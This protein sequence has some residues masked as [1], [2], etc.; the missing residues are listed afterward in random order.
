M[1]KDLERLL[2]RLDATT[3]GL[4]RELKTADRSLTDFSR[5]TD[6]HL[7]KINNSFAQLDRVGRVAARTLAAVGVG[8]SA[9]KVVEYSDSWKKLEGRLRVVTKTE[10]EMLSVRA[11]L[12]KM[13][14]ENRAS[15]SS[16][17]ELYSRLSMAVG[18]NA[19]AMKN[20]LPVTEAISKGIAVTGESAASAQGAIVQFSQGLATNFEA[21]G[22]EIRSL[23]EQA[24]RVAKALA[25]GLNELGIT[26]NATAGSLNKLASDGVINTTNSMQALVTQLPK[27]RKEFEK[28][29]RTVGQAMTNLDN[30][31]LTMLGTSKNVQESTNTLALGIN[32]LANN[33]ETVADAG[34]ILSGVMVARLVP[35]V[36]LSA[37]TAGGA[38]TAHF[39]LASALAGAVGASRTLAVAQTALA[40]SIGLA[41]TAMAM[42][43]GPVGLA[44]I[45]VV[46]ALTL[47]TNR[48]DEA[49]D[50]YNETLG[51]FRDQASAMAD[52]NG[53][54]RAEIEADSERIIKA[55]MAELKSLNSLIDA[56]LAY[57]DGNMAERALGGLAY[58]GSEVMGKL[59]IGNA[60]SELM[61][62]RDH[63]QKAITEMQ[64]LL[65]NPEAAAGGGSGGSGGSGGAGKKLKDLAKKQKE[66]REEVERTT[67]ELRRL[68][69]ARG[70]S[71]QKYEEVADAIAR[72]NELRKVG[73]DINSKEGKS[74]D[75]LLRQKQK[76]E[77][78]IEKIGDAYKQAQKDQEDLVREQER[79]SEQ[80]A[81][82]FQ[83]PFDNAMDNLQSS[84]RDKI[85]GG[86][87]G[88]FD[89]VIDIAKDLAAE[90]ATLFIF[91]PSVITSG[92]GVGSILSGST[93]A[94]AGGVGGSDFLSLGK[95]AYDFVSG[96][97]S[98]LTD[99]VLS[100]GV[101]R[102]VDSFGHSAFGI[103]VNHT[104]PAGVQGPVGVQG[105]F[106]NV[107]SPV[108]IGA[109]MAGSYAASALF[110]EGMGTSIGA[111]VGGL[112][113]GAA[114]AA[115]NLGPIGAAALIFGGSLLGGGLGSLF[116]KKPSSKLQSGQVDL[117][118]GEILGRGGLTGK[119][120]FSQ[121]NFDKVTTLSQTSAAL[122]QIIGAEGELSIAAGNR[123][124]LAFSF[125]H[126][127]HGISAY[128][129]AEEGLRGGF[130]NPNEFFDALI[131]EM[132][133]SVDDINESV[134]IALENIDF[135]EGEK[136]LA[137]ALSDVEF[138][139]AF[140]K[141]GE[142]P[143]IVSAVE[144]AIEA[145]N[146]SFEDMGETADRL[147]L[148]VD[149]ITE[150]QERAMQALTDGFNA[151]LTNSLLQKTNPGALALAAE[152]SR[153]QQ[154]LADAA[155]L[156]GDLQMVEALHAENM[157]EIGA[158]VDNA[159]IRSLTDERQLA[160]AISNDLLRLQNTYD[161]LSQ[162][163]AFGNLSGL[164]PVDQLAATRSRIDELSPLAQLGDLD[165]QAELAE[166]IPAFTELSGEVNGFNAEFAKDLAFTRDISDKT[167]EV[168]DRQLSVQQQIAESAAEEI[169][170]MQQGFADMV[171]ALS[172]GGVGSSGATN[173]AG[174]RLNKIAISGLG[175][176]DLTVGQ[177]E[178]I[179]RS[180]TGHTGTSGNG[181]LAA[182]ISAQGLQAQFDSL[183]KKAA[184]VPGFA[185]GGLIGG[186]L[187]GK[188]SVLIKAMPDEFMLRAAAV[189]SIG[190]DKVARMNATG[191]MPNNDN[192]AREIRALRSD[193]SKMTQVIAASGEMNADGQ[194]A[195]LGSLNKI[196]S[197]GGVAKWR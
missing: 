60:P 186:G 54:R 58:V 29:P 22:Q 161:S 40:G 93:T 88:G 24:P 48:A 141:L 89:D 136:A 63:L 74:L 37:T 124:G 33:L 121:A 39:A 177:V 80:L 189:K 18:N 7:G 76:H 173:A 77:A 154:Q 125:G 6:R 112:G 183:I 151:S 188:D 2:I 137:Q 56:Y 67:D 140:D 32:G 196:A 34:V 11:K 192:T 120:K 195:M 71:E 19:E 178:A 17:V 171:A 169:L 53:D 172:G 132:M 123:D 114:A 179:G 110:G 109:G 96:G 30:A 42:L 167:K 68:A 43:G 155:R 184:G 152:I 46:T 85:R 79:I 47:H 3:E 59:G 182:L 190:V 159:R 117:E 95:N 98:G 149:K 9:R 45:G 99:S 28:M 27:L 90:L 143:E 15:I 44:I 13:A 194:A 31:F 119:K 162:R 65:N 16:Q 92:L 49:Q 8:V 105:G 87:K 133:E 14:E 116:N 102:A 12:L 147:G 5:K 163:L 193:I 97:F 138:A 128:P 166:L 156:G 145:L 4:R 130:Q 52:A 108:N 64:Q 180:L 126:D 55:H 21:A 131:D 61:D 75:E 139:A 170:V 86:F 181:E 144:Q 160:V 148:S 164:S 185:G 82:E 158:Q 57:N 91:R 84:I 78:Q 153:Y 20:I 127:A 70:E 165:A 10:Q 23:Q 111:G 1:S 157:A 62:Q 41:G 135:G 168:I 26:S 191:Q 176:N 69:A 175:A 134:N 146:K 150:A 142:Q 122:A 72:E 50:R 36:A 83:R 197:D 38:A 113:A 115:L 73:L 187:T 104:L 174:T 25:D 106:S 100:G 103:G 51:A 35:A 118:T 101:G 66:F 107:F 94:G 81:E 129:T